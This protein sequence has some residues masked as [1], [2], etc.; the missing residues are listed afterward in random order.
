MTIAKNKL[1]ATK[2]INDSF[3]GAF[4]SAGMQVLIEEFLEG[5]ELS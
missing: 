5:K 2:A 3:D 1:D 4:G